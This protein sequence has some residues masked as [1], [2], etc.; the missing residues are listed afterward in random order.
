[1]WPRVQV[2]RPY[3]AREV[4]CPL[5]TWGL[6]IPHRLVG[7]PAN[8]LNPGRH[9]RSWISVRDPAFA[10]RAAPELDLYGGRRESGRRPLGP[11]DHVIWRDE[12]TFLLP[13][14]LSTTT[15]PPCK[16]LGDAHLARLLYDRRV[17]WPTWPP[18]TG[19]AA[20]RSLAVEAPT[21]RRGSI[22][23]QERE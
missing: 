8:A 13:V 9:H 2:E 1:V 17:R 6:G 16:T 22:D 15:L 3:L 4:A 23:V 18:G 5:Q 21:G 20:E 10:A 12:K 19:S 14:P 11:D 7:W